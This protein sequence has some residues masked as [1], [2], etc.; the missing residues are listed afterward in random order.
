MAEG[1]RCRARTRAARDDSGSGRQVLAAM[2][3]LVD[4]LQADSSERA[5]RPSQLL[6][7]RAHGRPRIQVELPPAVELAPPI[8]DAAYRVVQ[9]A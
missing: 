7:G 9:E 3:R 4:M 8:E 1:S 5:T 6:E 2:A